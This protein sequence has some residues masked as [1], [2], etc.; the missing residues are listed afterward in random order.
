MK[1]ESTDMSCGVTLANDLSSDE[2]WDA[3]CIGMYLYF[4]RMRMTTEP[5][6]R[7]LFGFVLF[8]D[9]T[10]SGGGSNLASY[11]ASNQLGQITTSP[12]TRNPNSGNEIQVWTFT[13]DHDVF[14]KWT[15]A[16][17]DYVAIHR[18]GKVP[19]G[20]YF[21]GD[22]NDCDDECDCGCND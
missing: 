18:A 14:R 5:Q 20:V 9:T 10:A 17:G 15:E 8:S 2:R 13:P 16:Q 22:E 12:A 6:L 11:F 7:P 19:P 3:V 1:F 21:D 4:Y